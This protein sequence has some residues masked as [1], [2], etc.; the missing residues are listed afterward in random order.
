MLPAFDSDD[1]TVLCLVGDQ[2]DRGFAV[3]TRPIPCSVRSKI[4]GSM[5][6]VGLGKVLHYLNVMGSKP[7]SHSMLCCVL[8][9]I[10]FVI[11]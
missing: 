7:T 2:L 6:T 4:S 10:F 1:C 9:Q 5:V 8:E 11:T 3:Y